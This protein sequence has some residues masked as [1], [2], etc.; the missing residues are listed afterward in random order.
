MTSAPGHLPAPAA[1][2][3]PGRDRRVRALVFQ[4]MVVGAVIIGMGALFAN[5]S[6][7]MAER[8]LTFDLGFLRS[9]AGFEIGESFV[10]YRPQDSYGQ[11]LLVGAINTL[12]ISVT[13]IVLATIL[14][15]VIGIARMSGN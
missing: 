11:A 1:R 10:P 7:E 5:L 6:S 14:G 13:G 8:R 15:L 2:V 12:V 3:P 4:A 9:T